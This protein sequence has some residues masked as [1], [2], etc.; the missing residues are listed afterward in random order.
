MLYTVN[1]RSSSM[2]LKLFFQFIQLLLTPASRLN[3][4][5]NVLT[6]ATSKIKQVIGS[7]NGLLSVS[8]NDLKNN[9]LKFVDGYLTCYYQGIGNSVET[10]I[11]ELKAY[12]RK[13]VTF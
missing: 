11:L 10:F 5:R 4:R 2:N 9:G 13:L 6:D 3:L 8:R 7:L 12:D 1:K